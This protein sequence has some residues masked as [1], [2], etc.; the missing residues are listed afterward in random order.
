MCVGE[1]R[2]RYFQP[3]H[4]CVYALGGDILSNC[5]FP[6]F[7]TANSYAGNLL[8]IN[9]G[10]FTKNFVMSAS[11][12]HF[13]ACPFKYTNDKHIL[14]IPTD[15][16]MC[17]CVY[18]TVVLVCIR[19]CPEQFKKGSRDN[20]LTEDQDGLLFF[21]FNTLHDL[22]ITQCV[23]ACYNNFFVLIYKECVCVYYVY[24]CFFSR[25]Q[26]VNTVPYTSFFV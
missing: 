22:L 4:K 10:E 25:L 9:F 26:C 17:A 6:F 19:F 2:E 12:C 7:F 23:F 14:V 3:A 20:K 5:W 16:N 11:F 21:F 24:H 1:Y 15:S 18:I 13:S 8:C